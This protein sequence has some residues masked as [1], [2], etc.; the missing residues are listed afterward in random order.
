MQLHPIFQAKES[1]VPSVTL[2]D[3]VRWG[4]FLYCPRFSRYAATDGKGYLNCC[5]SLWTACDGFK[6]I[7]CP[8]RRAYGQ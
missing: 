7:V 1:P 4:Y 3:S 8:P 6:L 2:G 5:E